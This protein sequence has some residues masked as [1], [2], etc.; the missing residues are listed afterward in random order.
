MI[1][2]KLISLILIII[3]VIMTAVGGWMDMKESGWRISRQHMW[4]DGVYITVLGI[5]VLLYSRM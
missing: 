3:G 1:N 2:A 4:N 5:F